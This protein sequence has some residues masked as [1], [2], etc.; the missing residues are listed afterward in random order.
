MPIKIVRTDSELE[1]PVI[2]HALRESGAEL[3]LLSDGVS[4]AELQREV[5]DA[6]LLLMYCWRAGLVSQASFR[7]SNGSPR[8]RRA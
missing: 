5:S 4:E 3:V 8:S 2:D 1:S 7:L 6:D